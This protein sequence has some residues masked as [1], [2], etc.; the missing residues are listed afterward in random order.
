MVRINILIGI[1]F[2]LWFVIDDDW[3]CALIC[4]NLILIICYYHDQFLPFIL[5]VTINAKIASTLQVVNINMHS[6][7]TKKKNSLHFSNSFLSPLPHTHLLFYLSLK[8]VIEGGKKK[9]KK[10]FFTLSLSLITILIDTSHLYL[11][12]KNKQTK[13]IRKGSKKKKEKKKGEEILKLF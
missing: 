1:N 12:W 5:F 11:Y 6:V 9:E 10:T 2:V 7:M 3:F 8:K 4:Y 13:N